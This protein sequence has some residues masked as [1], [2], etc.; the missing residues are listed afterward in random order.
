MKRTTEN[1]HPSH[2]ASIRNIPKGGP[3]GGHERDLKLNK[4]K[5]CITI[6]ID[7]YL[8]V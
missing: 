7:I 5:Y 8:L 1:N 3:D 6:K 2:P 4:I